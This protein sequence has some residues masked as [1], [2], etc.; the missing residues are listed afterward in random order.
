MPYICALSCVSKW[1]EQPHIL[2]LLQLMSGMEKGPEVDT[3]LEARLG[4]DSLFF[5]VA[6]FGETLLLVYSRTPFPLRLFCLIFNAVLDFPQT[7]I[8]HPLLQPN[9]LFQWPSPL[10]AP[11]SFSEILLTRSF[12]FLSLEPLLMA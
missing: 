6:S 8:L 10:V 11:F 4:L 1:K 7:A 2:S 3:K 9:L 5:R 12:P